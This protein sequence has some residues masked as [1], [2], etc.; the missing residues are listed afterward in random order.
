MRS[1]RFPRRRSFRSRSFPRRRRNLYPHQGGAWNR[2]QFHIKSLHASNEDFADLLWSD[3]LGI[4]EHI[5]R[6]DTAQGDVINQIARYVEVR[7]IR[8][9]VSGYYEPLSST[10]GVILQNDVFAGICVDTFSREDPVGIGAPESAVLFNPFENERPIRAISAAGFAEQSDISQPVRW[11]KTM[12][13][14]FNGGALN[15]SDAYQSNSGSF[16]RALN[17]A[18]RFRL[19]DQHRLYFVSAFRSNATELAPVGYGLTWSGAL[20]YRVGFGR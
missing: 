11:Q 17:V 14:S 4:S 18:R 7:A 3:I 8:C 1:F 19:D 5:G 15:A 20:W 13:H 10:A 2:C 12:W 6:Q 16:H 9:T